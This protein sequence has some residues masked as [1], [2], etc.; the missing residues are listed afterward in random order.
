MCHVIGLKGNSYASYV[1]RIGYFNISVG[2]DYCQD[3][4]GSVSELAKRNLA[5][6]VSS[7]SRDDSALSQ[8]LSTTEQGG[9]E[10]DLSRK[11]KASQ[12]LECWT[13]QNPSS[14]N[15]I[16]TPVVCSPGNST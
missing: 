16:M 8:K 12:T 2:L 3:G 13:S 4:V 11:D 7:F 15:D 1:Y 10:E 5:T 9:K 14:E 6:T